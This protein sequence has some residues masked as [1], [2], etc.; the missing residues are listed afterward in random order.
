MALTYHPAP[1]TIV[2]CDFGYGFRVPEMVKKRPAIVVSP[3]M[4]GRPRLCTVVPI[5][6]EAPH[7]P[8]PYHV[9]L[10]HLRLPPPYEDG[11]NWVKADMVFAVSFDRLDLFRSDRVDGRRSYKNISVEALDF[12]RIR[13][14]ILA[15]LGLN[16]LTKHI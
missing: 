5:S 11:P 15:G 6:S 7:R 14:A 2:I 3:Q 12:K 9:H 1:A 10:E 13:C 8:A 4:Q 16:H